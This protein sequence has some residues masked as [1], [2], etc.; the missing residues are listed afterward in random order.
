[1]KNVERDSASKYE[2]N[3]L[4]NKDTQKLIK[5]K[6][7][8]AY[9]VILNRNTEKKTTVISTKVFYAKSIDVDLDPLNQGKIVVIP[10]E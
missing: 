6:N 5:K 7:S 4:P 3:I 1:M 10:I 8:M 2:V 9:A